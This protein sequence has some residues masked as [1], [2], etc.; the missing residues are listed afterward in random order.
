MSQSWPGRVRGPTP[1]HRRPASDWP[2]ARPAA[3]WRR[4]SLLTSSWARHWFTG[5]VESRAVPP[6]PRAQVDPCRRSGRQS[7][8][9]TWPAAAKPC[10]RRARV[11][12]EG[13]FGVIRAAREQ[14]RDQVRAVG[15][16]SIIFESIKSIVVTRFVKS[17]LLDVWRR[18][19]GFKLIVCG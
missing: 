1:S 3:T 5:P 6:R 7:A 8:G 12:G 14:F 13:V 10:S 9:V 17:L 2:A 19:L 16:G 15:L 18:F 4:P 11:R